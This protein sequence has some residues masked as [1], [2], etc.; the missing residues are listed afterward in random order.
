MDTG[1]PPPET[2]ELD[3]VLAPLD[4]GEP[5]S[6]DVLQALFEHVERT[7]G[8]RLPD[9][10]VAFLGRANGAE[11]ELPGGNPVVLFEAQV[12][13]QANEEMETEVYMPGF[14]VIG[15]D[16]GDYPVG[17]DMRHD[18]PAER[19]VETEDAGMDWDY[20]LWRGSSFLELLRYLEREN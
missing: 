5:A 10:Y 12:L 4:L 18:A 8:T 19:Y 16:T 11:G 17:I 15:G 6:E 3:R 2:D 7:Y 9:D 1:T 13:K 14:F 20:V